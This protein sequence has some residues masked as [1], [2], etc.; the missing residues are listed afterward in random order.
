MSSSPTFIGCLTQEVS[1]V[2][3]IFFGPY[4]SEL[5]EELLEVSLGAIVRQVADKQLV[6]VRI[7]ARAASTATHRSATI[8]KKIIH[9]NL[10]FCQNMDAHYDS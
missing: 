10:G 8:L 5:A 7:L 3:F 4:L 2:L 6:R 1:L 9:S